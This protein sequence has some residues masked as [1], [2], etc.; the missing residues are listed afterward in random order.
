VNVKAVFSP[1]GASNH[2]MIDRAH[3]DFYA[4]A[5]EAIVR[6]YKNGSLPATTTAVWE[7]ACG[8]GHISRTLS[9]LGYPVISSDLYDRGYGLANID[10]LTTKH[11]QADCII[12]NPPY[13]LA[14]PFIEHGMALG[15]KLQYHFL[16]LTFLESKS[17]RAFFNRYPPKNVLVFSERITVARNGEPE[18]FAKGSAVCY[19]WFMWDI[20]FTGAPTISWL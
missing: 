20:A 16:K 2:S 17:R 19:A 1:L 10:F 6:L 4:T 15:V 7:P 3:G 5:P 18:E 8:A 14:L 11:K 12:T 9:D 13:K